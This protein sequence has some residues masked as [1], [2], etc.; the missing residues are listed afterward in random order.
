MTT[1]GLERSDVLRIACAAGA[2]MVIWS[3]AGCRADSDGPGGYRVS[4]DKP[5]F[6]TVDFREGETLRYR[7]AS[8]RNI[9]LDWDPGA[10]SSRNRVQEQSEE[11]ET[12]VAY[13]PIKVDPYGVST[14]LAAVESARATRSGGAGGRIYGPDAAETAQG[15][16]FEI[17]VDPRG[18]I[19]EASSLN[20]L[21]Q[22]MGEAAFRTGSRRGRIKEPD[23][24]GDF[25]AGQWFLWDAVASIPQ[26][27]AGVTV[28]RTWPSHLSVPTPMVMRKARDVVYRLEDISPSEEGPVAVI[29]SIYTLAEAVP[30]GWPVPY[31]GRFQMSGTFGFLGAYEVL[32][33]E[34]TGEE[35]F[36]LATGRTE[37][38]RQQYTLRMK[39]VLP[40]MGIRANPHLTIDQTLTM[41]LLRTETQNSKSETRS[42]SE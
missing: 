35:L 29:T 31:S 36:N 30:P 15:K 19:A 8:R 18:R 21:L 38:R 41:E 12:V 33:L 27:A 9:V 25:V 16:T 24:I 10:A 11:L 42:K 23:L 40:P 7:F 17:K 6:L 37:R 14:I 1:H 28:G 2:A 34:G 4:R 5:V 26:P 22:E 3:M 39:A 13:T 32:G 20:D